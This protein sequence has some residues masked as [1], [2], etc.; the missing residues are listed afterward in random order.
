AG[1]LTRAMAVGGKIQARMADRPAGTFFQMQFFKL[2]ALQSLGE[3]APQII[4]PALAGDNKRVAELLGRVARTGPTGVIVLAHGR[5]LDMA[6][7]KLAARECYRRAAGMPSV[8]E[9]RQ[10]ALCLYVESVWDGVVEASGEVPDRIPEP[11]RAEISRGVRD[12]A[13]HGPIP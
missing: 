4:T 6:G 8:I 13:A 10:V 2:P 3:L 12:L 5:Y 11:A 1:L 9:C 7:D